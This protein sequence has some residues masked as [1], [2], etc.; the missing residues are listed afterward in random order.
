[1]KS[2]ATGLTYKRLMRQKLTLIN[3]QVESVDSG[4]KRSQIMT[5]EDEKPGKIS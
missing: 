3:D 4:N 5:Q 2:I 1:M